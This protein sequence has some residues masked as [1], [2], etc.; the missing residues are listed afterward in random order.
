MKSFPTLVLAIFS[1]AVFAQ[2]PNSFYTFKT[3]DIDGKPFDF[4]SLK[5]KKV[6]IVNTASQCGNTPQYEKLQALWDQYKSKNFIIIGFPANNF[7]AQEP[8]SNKEI[9]EF[10]TSN[11]H[12]TFPMM[13]K[14][15]VKGKDIDP[16]YK[17]LTTKSENG[18]MDA[19]VTWNFQKFMID[20]NGK[21]VGII[22]PKESP[23]SPKILDWIKGD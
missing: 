1:I 4:S 10:C 17:W 8:G 23:Q 7:G 22:P 12:V 16:I 9:K 2:S 19:E 20:E 21:L 5:G 11:Y 14:I 3:T 18:V 13:A 15:S 6:L